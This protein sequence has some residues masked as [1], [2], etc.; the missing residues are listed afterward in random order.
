MVQKT[1]EESEKPKLDINP[2]MRKNDRAGPLQPVK[3]RD[4]TLQKGRK[5]KNISFSIYIFIMNSKYKQYKVHTMHTGSSSLLPHIKTFVRVV[6][7]FIA[8]AM[9]HSPMLPMLLLTT[10][11]LERK[12]SSKLLKHLQNL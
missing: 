9:A 10:E 6:F 8:S 7:V 5:C 4:I 12:R 11:R 1:S 2:Q 3:E